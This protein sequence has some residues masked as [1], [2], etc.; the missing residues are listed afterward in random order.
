MVAVTKLNKLLYNFFKISQ[1]LNNEHYG[2]GAKE[3]LLLFEKLADSVFLW[4]PHRAE[5]RH[6]F[7]A[8]QADRAKR[9][10]RD[11]SNLSCSENTPEIQH[12]EESTKKRYK[13]K[14]KKNISPC[15]PKSLPRSEDCE[16]P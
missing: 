11:C 14:K 4:I 3:G 15:S 13:T 1:L 8:D 12:G 7:T 2:Q 16:R 6:I 9:P 5:F 10:V